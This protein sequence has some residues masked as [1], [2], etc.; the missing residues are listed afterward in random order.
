MRGLQGRKPRIR[1]TRHGPSGTK[2][3]KHLWHAGQREK[4]MAQC[5]LQHMIECGG[6]NFPKYLLLDLVGFCKKGIY[7]T[8]YRF[9]VFLCQQ[10]QSKFLHRF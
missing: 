2:R 3:E 5:R 6:V 1:A 4:N 8:C 9:R 10:N 7:L